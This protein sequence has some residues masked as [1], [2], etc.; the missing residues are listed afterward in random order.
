MQSIHCTYFIAPNGARDSMI[1][2]S[3]H[4]KSLAR[5]HISSCELSLFI[6][7]NI[8][9]PETTPLHNLSHRVDIYKALDTPTATISCL[10]S[11]K[12]RT[13]MLN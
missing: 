8:S 6:L 10:A 1:I 7:R 4:E 5:S 3:V 11:E 9:R 2:D 13:A 12:L